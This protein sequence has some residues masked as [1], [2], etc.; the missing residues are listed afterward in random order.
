V[1]EDEERD[2]GAV[3]PGRLILTIY[4][5]YAREHDGWLP[6]A[7]VVRLMSELGVGVQAVR[8]ATHRLKRRG[9]LLAERR[10]DT[11]GY[12]LS[13]GARGLLAEGD[14]RI[15]GHRRGTVDDGWLLVVFSVP[16][17]EKARRY[18]LRSTLIRLG[19]GTVSPGTWVAP[20][21]LEPAVRETLDRL[22][23]TGFTQLFTGPHVGGGELR[24]L[25]AA[26]WDL[27]GLQALYAEFLDRFG[28]VGKRWAEEGWADEDGT[29]ARAFADHV[30]MLTAWRRLPYADPGLPL[31]LLP[32]DW[33][34]LR[35]EQLFTDLSARLSAP[36]ARHAGTVLD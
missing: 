7:A 4:G 34:G 18:Q 32:T 25:V 15:F 11:A 27:D 6:I 29:D 35:A 31:E 20:R 2:G 26:W 9:L 24:E 36:A 28:P 17:T 33:N 30:E 22:D 21:H 3:Q 14:V 12:A 19:L 8:S 13:V 10:G 16:D 23:L 5:L 1:I